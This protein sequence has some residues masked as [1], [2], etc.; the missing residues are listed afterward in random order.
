MGEVTYS[1]KDFAGQA[2][3]MFGTT[4]EAVTAALRLAGKEAATIEEA[5]KIVKE[6][7]EKEVK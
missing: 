4:P 7:L 2:K 3:R 6:F 5:K 1:I